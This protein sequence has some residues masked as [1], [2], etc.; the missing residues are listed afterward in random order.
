MPNDKQ[1]LVVGK[2]KITSAALSTLLGAWIVELIVG[3][4]LA[5]G[6]ISV[7]LVSYYNHTLGCPEVNVD[8]FYGLQ[9]LMVMFSMFFFPLGNHLVDRLGGTRPVIAIG[10]VVALSIVFVCASYKFSPT[11]FLWLFSFAMGLYKGFI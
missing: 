10:G 5:M 3:A 9:P 11:V 1:Q 4:I 6:N 2:N 8:T 7:Y